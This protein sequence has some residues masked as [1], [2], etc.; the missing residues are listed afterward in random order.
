MAGALVSR[1]TLLEGLVLEA[2]PSFSVT[3]HSLTLPISSSPIIVA[4]V[5]CIAITFSKTTQK[6][7]RCSDLKNDNY[8]HTDP[9]KQE[10]SII[11]RIYKF[12]I[13]SFK[14]SE[15]DLGVPTAL[16]RVIVVGM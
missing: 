16:R 6:I 3:T 14:A 9:D 8:S 5:R 10:S 13:I 4:F 2:S 7:T 12:H 1:G 11:L 15:E